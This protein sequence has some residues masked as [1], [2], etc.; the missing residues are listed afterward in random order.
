MSHKH[1][2]LDADESIFFARELEHVKSKSYDKKY[3]QL[4][5]R[6]L[7]PVSSDAGAGAESI[8]YEQYDAVGLAKVISSYADDLPRADVKG[9]QFTSI[10]KSLGASFGYSIQEIRA[11]Q[12]AGKPLA[13]RKA[14]AAKK[15][16]L[17][18][19][20]QVA[21]SGDAVNNI[22]GFLNNAN[23]PL[24]VLPA[25]G[26]GATIT[27]STKTPDKILRDLNTLVN[28]IVELTK[29]VEI[30]DTLLLPTTIYNLLKNTP[31]SSANDGKSILKLFLENQEYIKNVFSVPRLE[32]A[33]AGGVKR[34]AAYRRDPEVLTL[35]IPQDF[36][37]LEEQPRGLEY[38][39][40]CHSRLGGVIVYYPLACAFSD[41]I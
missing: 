33:G 6:M 23:I 15:A 3:A 20:D 25:D 24:V 36:E 41:G 37:M 17:T 31:W 19:E 32:S 18:K 21:F 8:T 13:Q 2:L 30:P 7:F 5:A 11:A 12:M 39:T 38:I 40:P 1:T 28:S 26:A 9:K 27:F 14:D 35:E 16:I 29:E 34:M 22:Q 4:K 10:V